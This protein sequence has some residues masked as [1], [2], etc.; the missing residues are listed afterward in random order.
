MTSPE[1]GEVD[2]ID[3][4]GTWQLRS[5]E[6]HHDDGSIGRPFGEHAVGLLLYDGGG[7]MAGAMMRAGRPGFSRPRTQATDFTAGEP[8]ELAAAFNSFLAY[9]GRWEI[10]HP[11][12]IRHHV[13]VA[14]IPGWA[15]TTLWRQARRLG[16]ELVLTTP[17]RVIDG[18]T[19]RGVLRWE[20]RA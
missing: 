14:S 20:R 10:E 3:L 16:N 15:G 1:L 6:T 8:A 18:R 13:E 7:S 4:H 12:I 9:S 2:A 17:E 5:W 11:D 19:Q